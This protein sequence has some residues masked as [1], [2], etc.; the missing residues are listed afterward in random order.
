[1][2]EWGMTKSYTHFFLDWQC[3]RYVIISI[4]IPWR[5]G[6]VWRMSV[7]MLL[8]WPNYHLLVYLRW[9]DD[10]ELK[11]HLQQW[12]L[13]ELFSLSPQYQVF[14]I[15]LSLAAPHAKQRYEEQSYL[16]ATYFT[17]HTVPNR[18]PAH[19]SR[20]SRRGLGNIFPRFIHDTFFSFMVVWGFWVGVFSWWGFGPV[21]LGL[22]GFLGL[23]LSI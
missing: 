8:L 23:G 10:F 15:F 12:H 21:L 16:W 20:T 18:I 7:S 2:R 3:W 5:Q 13:S 14:W 4:L 1:M 9:S 22:L 19:F 11:M 17:S 6:P